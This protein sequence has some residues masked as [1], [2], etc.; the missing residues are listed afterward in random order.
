MASELMKLTNQYC[1]EGR[2]SGRSPFLR[3]SV[4]I[5]DFKLVLISAKVEKKAFN[6]LAS[7][8]A[9]QKKKCSKIKWMRN[10]K[11]GKNH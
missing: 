7:Q 2:A 8:N 4:Y 10:E 9:Q 5:L 3:P 1:D 11:N 6:R